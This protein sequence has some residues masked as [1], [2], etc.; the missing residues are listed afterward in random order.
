MCCS[1]HKAIDVVGEEQHK[2]T[3]KLWFSTCI[4]VTNRL[5]RRLIPIEKEILKVYPSLFGKWTTTVCSAQL[6]LPRN[7]I[8]L[9]LSHM[10][11]WLICYITPNEGNVS[12]SVWLMTRNVYKVYNIRNFSSFLS[13]FLHLMCERSKGLFIFHFITKG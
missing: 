7:K 9:Q 4:H 12:F 6:A 3:L 1:R 10:L 13:P 8:V 11:H 2:I 5:H